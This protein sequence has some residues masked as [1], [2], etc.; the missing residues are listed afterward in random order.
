MLFRS[1]IAPELMLEILDNSAAKS[2]LVSFKAPYVLA[3]DFHALFAAK[4]MHKD[5]TLALES[6]NEMD[7]PLPLTSLTAQMLKAVVARGWGDDDFSS[8]FRTMEEWAGV[9]IEKA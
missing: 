6:G 3:R 4:W 1:G 2:G 9:K 7:V 5:I 8:L